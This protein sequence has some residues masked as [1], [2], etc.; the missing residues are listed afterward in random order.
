MTTDSASRRSPS[1]KSRPA[2]MGTP[3]AAKKPGDTVRSCARGSSSPG[4][5][6][7]PS[8]EKA[9]PGPKLPASRQG[10]TVPT[11]TRSTPGSVGDPPHR[12]LVE[13]DV[14]LGRPSVGDAAGDVQGEHATRVEPGGRR[15]QGEQ[16]LHQHAGPR[17][18]HEGRGDLRDGEDAQ[19]AA[20]AAGD[21]HAPV[22]QAEPLGTARRR[23]PRHEGQED[24][25]HDGQ[26]RSHPEQAGV[27][28]E[29]ERPHREPRRVAAQDGHH[30]P[31]AQHAERGPAPQRMR[32]SASR[33]RRSAP[34]VAPS[35]ARMA[36]SPSR[37]T[38]RARIRLATFEQAMTKTRAEAA[39]RTSRTDRARDVS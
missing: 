28:G 39:R 37:R 33:V 30:R 1:L 34:L 24:G 2:M 5:E 16:R 8:A 27:D 35:D 14:L 29:V 13:R 12:F 17:Q 3:S 15:L 21:A 11:A 36:S 19:P 26:E 25:G 10:T 7:R 32:L 20:R 6:T 31:R 4:M 18:Q 38:V 22:G 23:Q 9:K